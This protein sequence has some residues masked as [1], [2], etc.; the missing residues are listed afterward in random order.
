MIKPTLVNRL[1]KLEVRLAPP[2]GP[3]FIRILYVAPDGE[4]TG[5]HV[6][7]VGGY[8]GPIPSFSAP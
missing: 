2:G 1:K 8:T 3:Q 5:E 4:I 6:V 7:S